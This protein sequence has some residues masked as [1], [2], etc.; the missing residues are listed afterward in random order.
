MIIAITIASIVVITISAW[1]IRKIIKRNICPICV[2][3]SLTWLWTLI[4]QW[5]GE[6]SAAD[7]QLPTAILMGG[8]V[9][10]AMAKLERFIEP[11]F[12]LVWKTVFAVSGF[13]AVFCLVTNN[14]PVLIVGIIGTVVATLAGK[15]RKA[16]EIKPMTEKI[17]GLKNKMENCC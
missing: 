1:I 5:S 13:L 7:Y 2:G 17:E 3:V 16:E 11:N 9:V 12:V 14:W 6:L 10:G 8:T 15:K 4:G